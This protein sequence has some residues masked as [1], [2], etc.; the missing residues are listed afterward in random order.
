MAQKIDTTSILI[1][2]IIVHDIPNI[3]REKKEL[4]P[5]T[6]NRKAN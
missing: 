1:E 5:I 6:A 3:K 4:N 2:R